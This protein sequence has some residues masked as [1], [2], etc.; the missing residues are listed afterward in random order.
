L[1]RLAADP[2]VPADDSLRLIGR[3]D[4]R[5][6]N[7]WMHNAPRLVKGKTRHHLLMHPDDMA[8]RGLRD[9]ARVRLSSDTGEVRIAARACEEMMPG[10][11]CLPHG[12]GHDRVGTRQQQAE[13]VEGASYNDLTDA[14][15]LDLPSGNAALNGLRVRVSAE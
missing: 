1:A 7:S 10:V 5:S 4:V 14:H 13:R 11:A 15:E 6:N 2:S 8:S 9:G 3:R 12:F